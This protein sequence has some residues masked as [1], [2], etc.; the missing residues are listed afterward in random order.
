MT[1]TSRRSKPWEHVAFRLATSVFPLRPPQVVKLSG[2]QV[3][4]ASLTY[5]V[6]VCLLAAPE[7]SADMAFKSPSGLQLEVKWTPPH[8]EDCS[9]RLFGMLTGEPDAV[10]LFEPLKFPAAIGK[11][12]AGRGRD[13]ADLH[14]PRQMSFQASE[15]D[16]TERC[17]H[18]LMRSACAICSRRQSGRTRTRGRTAQ[19]Q[20][21]ID[22]L[23]LILPLLAPS[24][25][26]NFDN[27]MSFPPGKQLYPFQ[28]EG[29]RFLAE[30]QSALLGDE[31]GLGKSI[32]AIIALRIVVR[33]GKIRRTLLLCPKSVL[34]DWYHKLWEWSPELVVHLVRGPKQKRE[35]SWAAVG[36][37]HLTTYEMLR[38]DADILKGHEFQ[39]CLLDEIQRIKNPGTGITRAVR[40]IN[41]KFRWGLSGTPL[42]NK[43]DDIL[44][45][46]AYLKP[47]LLH[48]GDADRPQLVKE[49][50]RPYFLRRRAREVLPDL[51]EKV[52]HEVWLDLGPDQRDSY[53]RAYHQGCT[54]LRDNRTAIHAFALI[55]ELKQICNLDPLTGESV[56]LD[57]LHE[58]LEKLPAGEK[59][60]VFS[61]Y[62]TKTLQRI[63][64][65]L[66]EFEPQLFDGQ[67]SDLARDHMVREFQEGETSKLLLMS[68]KAGSLGLTLTRASY[69]FHFDLW[70]NPATAHQA[71]GRAHRIGQQKTVFVKTLYTVDTIEERIHRILARKKAL[72]QE[73]IED[74]SDTF[75]RRSLT[76][77][78]LFGLF[79]LE[80][81]Q[82][83]RTS[84]PSQRTSDAL[85]RLNPIEFE[86]L[87]ARLYEKM[88]F[89]AQLTQA[90]HDGGV[91]IYAKRFTDAGAEV[92]IIQCKHYF[93][94]KVGV[95]AARDLYGTLS[96]KADVG[97]AVLV[98]TGHFSRECHEFARGKNVDLMPLEQLMGLLI[99]Y[100]LPKAVGE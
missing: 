63:K 92:L 67:L 21:V 36:H 16:L 89:A 34:Y 9:G 98:T 42:E 25:G 40:R 82:P 10:S 15:K 8:V 43:I 80:P 20:I 54:N 4:G 7:T 24:L 75:V 81:A 32:Q 60:L 1:L 79:D 71:E 95:S 33:H 44:S 86:E 26:E 73:V 77:E 62:P 90:S 2:L 39:L 78:E 19:A 52:S 83:V 87:V 13:S 68:V 17:R 47:D 72:F 46:F 49:R 23:D 5:R 53:D 22:P 59:A 74:L 18:G 69:V 57:Y 61:Q 64:P 84:A 29:V 41:A 65:H 66:E 3:F 55:T 6:T 31:M 11:S 30:Q 37:V 14:A 94:G 56:K 93:G 96:S 27:V 100:N 51:P 45:I 97:R 48:T 70:W 38:Q 12:Y 91:D 28:H 50:I 58:Q 35:V 76:E 88:G 99:K 85:R